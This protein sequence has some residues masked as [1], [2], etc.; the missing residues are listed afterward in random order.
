VAAGEEPDLKVLGHGEFGEEAAALGDPGDALARHVVGGEGVEA[1]ASR[2][3]SPA[4]AGTSPMIALSAVDLPAPLRPMRQRT[5]PAATASER[6]RR[7][8]TGP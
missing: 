3:I 2:R 6:P 1:G 8:C 4:V 7:T 5:S